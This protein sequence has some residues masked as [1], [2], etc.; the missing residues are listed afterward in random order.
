[1]GFGRGIDA[2]TADEFVAMYVNDL[3]L[4]MGDR[5]RAAIDAAARPRARV[6]RLMSSAR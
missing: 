3:T 4:D 5:G 2:G 6:R 1:M